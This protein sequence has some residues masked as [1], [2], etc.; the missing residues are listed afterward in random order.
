MQAATPAPGSAPTARPPAPAL[1]PIDAPDPRGLPP[2]E[3]F[4]AEHEDRT[5]KAAT[6]KTLH[7]RLAKLPGG[8][9]QIECKQTQCLL[10]FGGSEQDIS[11]ALDQLQ[12]LQ[13]IA[14][15]VTLTRDGKTMRAYLHF[16]RP[17]VD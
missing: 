9:P 1:P 8:P 5:W 16:E 11:R 17:D 15:H 3:G 10:T 14:Q 2:A 13:D 6:E 4:A 12:Q 7:E